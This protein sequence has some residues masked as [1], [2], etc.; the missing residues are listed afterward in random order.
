MGRA[1]QCWVSKSVGGRTAFAGHL[2]GITDEALSLE[3]PDGQ[4]Y[5][6]PRGLVTKARLAID[7]AKAVLKIIELRKPEDPQLDTMCL[8][9]GRFSAIMLRLKGSTPTPPSSLAARAKHY[10][11][12]CGQGKSATIPRGNVDLLKKALGIDVATLE[13]YIAANKPAKTTTTKT[14]AVEP[15]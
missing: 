11:A 6:L 12:F 3:E 10:E 1:I 4:L 9:I 13:G 8:R 15:F 5:E 2:R 7:Q 14:T